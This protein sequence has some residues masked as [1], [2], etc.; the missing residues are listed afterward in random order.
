MPSVTV[1]NYLKQVFLEQQECG[2]GM[3]PMGRVA[4]AMGVVPGTATTMM[5]SLAEAGW[6]EYTPR[7]GVRLTP[8]GK[9]AALEILR[10]HRLIE[11]FLVKILGLDWTEIH[12]D[13]EAL[14]HAVSDRVLQRIDDLCGNPKYDP[15][16]DPIP[17]AT[18]EY[19]PRPL[20]NLLE[21]PMDAKLRVA[22][23][24][25]QAPAFLQYAHDKGLVPGSS[26][27]V[28][29]RNPVADAVTLDVVGKG[30]LTLGGKVASC[31]KVEPC[32]GSGSPK[33]SPS[34]S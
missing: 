2:G 27:R 3:V 22:R 28:L 13:A 8:E 25:N 1:E 5:K 14:E 10:R 24:L 29:E 31:I 6:A 12:E 7:K 17:T 16:G 32:E 4:T 18:G 26:V 21:C 33:M 34:S 23:I 30:N 20:Q 11:V 9:R 19:R 15:H